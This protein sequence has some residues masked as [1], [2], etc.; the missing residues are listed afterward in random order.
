[1]ENLREIIATNIINLRKAKNW[2]QVELARRINFSDKAVSRWEKGEVMPDIETIQRLS[3]V[4]DVPMTAII[5]KQ[6][7]QQQETKTKPTKQEVLSQIFLVCEI[8][9]I[10]SVA[11]AYLNISSG[12]NVWKI[13]LWG[14]PATVLLLY[15]VNLRHKHNVSSFVYGTIFIW[16]FTA[17][18]FIQM[19]H[20]HAWFFFIL[21]IPI[22]GMLVVRYLVKHEQRKRK[23]EE[24]K[25]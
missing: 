8:W 6:K 9:T 15:I 4:F 1:M 22:Q 21:G 23:D 5:E 20:L 2:T 17:C 19:I 12:L 10:L 3:E 24:L 7:N 13:F 11:Y 16:T 14:V 25:N 18:L